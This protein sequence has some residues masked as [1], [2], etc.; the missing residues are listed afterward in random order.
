MT[1]YRL[2]IVDE[3][4]KDRIKSIAFFEDEFEC[5]EVPLEVENEDEL[6]DKIIENNLDAV[7]ID[8]KLIDHPKLAFNGNLVLKKLMNEKYNFPAF[9]L[10]NL[11]PDA[12]AEDI[13]DFRIISKR[14]VNPELQEGKELINKLKNYINKYYKEIEKKEEE[15]FNLI[16]K[17]KKEELTDTE[18]EKMIEL[19]DFLE[20][21]FSQKSKIP[22][23][24]KKPEGFNQL[25]NL[26]SKTEEL[27]TELKKRNG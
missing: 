13:D 12:S 2:G 6:I 19:D 15:L 8:Y 18:R 20:H 7:A 16:Q 4:E 27:L 21:S 17:E 9:I 11:V 1:K 23:G 3:S 22:T 24:W 26:V 5:V 25:K 14:A 10:T